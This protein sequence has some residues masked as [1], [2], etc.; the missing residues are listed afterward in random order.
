MGLGGSGGITTGAKGW[1][2]PRRRVLP[3]GRKELLTASPQ[4][5]TSRPSPLPRGAFRGPDTLPSKPPRRLPLL[6]V[7][8]PFL[9]VLSPSQPQH[10]PGSSNE[11]LHDALCQRTTAAC[12]M[13]EPSRKS[14]P[15]DSTLKDPSSGPLSSRTMV[16]LWHAPNASTLSTSSIL[17]QGEIP[18]HL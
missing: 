6:R 13:P 5:P 1:G 18:S 15:K 17:L 8:C 4:N 12:G 7:P 16:M 10:R 11:L 14:R 2:G 3:G 9:P